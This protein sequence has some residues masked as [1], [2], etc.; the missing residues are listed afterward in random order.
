MKKTKLKEMADRI[1]VRRK[2]LMFTQETFSEI[3]DISYGSYVRIENAFQKPSLDTLI[4][5]A[6][7][8]DISLDYIVLGKEKKKPLLIS[9]INL[10]NS[11]LS[12][13]KKDELLRISQLLEKMAEIK[14]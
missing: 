3:I 8:L 10:L 12:S 2:E 6:E 9:D 13:A 7:N 11:I 14:K 5:I 4:K 1:K